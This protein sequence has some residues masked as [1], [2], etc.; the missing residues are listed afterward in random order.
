LSKAEISTTV[1]ILRTWLCWYS[2]FA[3][4]ESFLRRK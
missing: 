3:T 2:N 4:K 1:K